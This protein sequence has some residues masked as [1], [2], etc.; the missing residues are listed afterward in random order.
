MQKIRFV[1]EEQ[2][3]GS[4]FSVGSYLVPIDQLPKFIMQ[5]RSTDIVVSSE[6]VQLKGE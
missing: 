4:G 5:L 3:E 2:N 6:L 1:V